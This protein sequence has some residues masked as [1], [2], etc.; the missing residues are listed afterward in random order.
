PCTP[1]PPHTSPVTPTSNSSPPNAT[2]ENPARLSWLTSAPPTRSPPACNRH[3]V[4]PSR[5]ASNSSAS[6]PRLGAWPKGFS[7]SPSSTG[8]CPS[9]C[10]APVSVSICCSLL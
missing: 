4:S 7:S 5:H 9:G 2:T 10:Q 6:S 1:H 8:T 3:P